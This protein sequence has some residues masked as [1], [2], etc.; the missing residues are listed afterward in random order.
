MTPDSQ[1]K[2]CPVGHHLSFLPAMIGRQDSRS[3]SPSASNAILVVEADR[4]EV[5]QRVP[6][7]RSHLRA[8]N[9]GAKLQLGISR[10]RLVCEFVY[11]R[12]GVVYQLQHDVS[13]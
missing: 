13:P 12:Y 1:S 3:W 4:K 11:L 7:L 6:L 2:Q 9:E 8:D 10:V 5:D